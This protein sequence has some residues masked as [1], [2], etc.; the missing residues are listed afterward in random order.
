MDIVS[1]LTGMLNIP[2][3]I[4]GLLI[5]FVVKHVISD[6]TIQNKWIPVINVVVGAVL[7][8]VLCVT[9]GAAVTA[10]AILLAVIGGAVSCVASSGCYDAFAAFIE[11][12]QTD[13]DSTITVDTEEAVG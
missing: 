6:E 11:K 8:V 9:G 10:E 12:G 7:G 5:G 1:E 13:D 3:L 4:L 2:I